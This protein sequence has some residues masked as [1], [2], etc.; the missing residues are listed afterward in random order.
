MPFADIL[1]FVY[2]FFLFFSVLIGLWNY[3]YIDKKV[4][5]IYYL[6]VATT[7][8]ETI[9]YILKVLID[10]KAPV[11]HFSCV[12]SLIFVSIY[13]IKSIEI[14]NEKN[15]ILF[16]T[17][18]FTTIGVIDTL[19]F[20]TITQL[21]SNMLI[22]RGFVLIAISLYALYK[23]F[24]ND[25]LDNIYKNVHFWLWALILFL[26]G[27]SYFFWSYIKILSNDGMGKYQN[28]LLDIHGLTN[29]IVYGGFFLIFSLYP[30]KFTQ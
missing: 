14:K 6:L 25:K 4:K 2:L 20:E 24:T 26:Y 10:R 17:L 18:T 30:K 27:S 19:C 12:L 13:F 16:S 7:I 15:A 21:N 9:G 28:I 11:Y 3:K 23:I 1:N 8:W 29:V 5:I 22:F